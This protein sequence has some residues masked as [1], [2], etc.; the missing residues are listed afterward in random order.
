METKHTVNMGHYI[1][2]TGHHAV[3]TGHALSLQQPSPLQRKHKPPIFHQTINQQRFPHIG[4]NSVSSIIG[5]YKFCLY[6]ICPPFGIR[7]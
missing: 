2:K 6:K 3:E 5:S 7:L 4:K 1:V